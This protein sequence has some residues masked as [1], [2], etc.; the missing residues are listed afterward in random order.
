MYDDTGGHS[1]AHCL[2]LIG[3]LDTLEEGTLKTLE[4]A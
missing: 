1:V 3:C 4:A 2:Q